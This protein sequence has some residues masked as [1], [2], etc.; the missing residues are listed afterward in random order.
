MTVADPA[1]AILQAVSDGLLSFSGARVRHAARRSELRRGPRRAGAPLQQAGRR[2]SHRAQRSLPARDPAR[3]G[4]RDDVD[5]DRPLQRRDAH[6]LRQRR[7]ARAVRRRA[8]ARRRGLP[9]HPRPRPARLSRGHRAG[10]RHHL[11]RRERGDS[12]RPTQPG[13]APTPARP[14]CR[15]PTTWRAATSSSACSPTSS[16]SSSR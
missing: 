8:Q 3:D 2:A 16:S 13:R 4:A 6:R 14:A 12:D 15:R 9:R 11:Q 1:T 7:R 5:G 10:D